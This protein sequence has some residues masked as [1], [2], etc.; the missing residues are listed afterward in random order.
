MNT[1]VK[2]SL[3][4]KKEVRKVRMVFI[5]GREYAEKRAY[6]G[7]C[8]GR[9]DL[10][11]DCWSEPG[12]QKGKLADICLDTVGESMYFKKKNK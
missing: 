1:P 7:I 4:G 11:D 6:D 2:I 10:Y 9:C 3:N 5:D 12:V 8:C